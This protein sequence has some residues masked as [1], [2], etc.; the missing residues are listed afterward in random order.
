MR[1]VITIAFLIKLIGADAQP[2]LTGNISFQDLMKRERTQELYWTNPDSSKETLALTVLP[3]PVTKEIRLQTEAFTEKNYGLSRIWLQP[4]II[5]I[6]SMDFDNL[7]DALEKSSFLH[8]RM[9]DSWGVLT[10]AGSLPNGAHFIIDRSGKVY[11]IMPPVADEKFQE[12]WNRNTHR[13]LIRRHQDGNPFGV[14][15]EN[16]T[17]VN[18]RYDDLTPEQIDAN[19]KLVRWLFWFDGPSIQYLTS[20][21]QYNDSLFCQSMLN[22]MGRNTPLNQYRTKQRMDVGDSTLQLIHRSV[23]E[24][25]LRLKNTF[26]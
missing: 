10:K 13:W 2:S 5:V 22:K 7:Q 23:V 17:S 11:C 12:S 19:A 20:H 4:K 14:G 1:Y 26:D 18:G 25:G 9:P 21:H 15:I 6:H 8:H 24:K 16:L 3:I